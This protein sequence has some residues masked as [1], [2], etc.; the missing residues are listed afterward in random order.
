[1][2]REAI[3]QHREAARQLAIADEAS[4]EVRRL[5]RRSLMLPVDRALPR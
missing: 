1:M 5:H 4:R 3:R 2:I